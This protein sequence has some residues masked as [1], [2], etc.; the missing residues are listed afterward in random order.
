MTSSNA[1]I[2]VPRSVRLNIINWWHVALIYVPYVAGLAVAA[3]SARLGMLIYAGDLQWSGVVAVY[4]AVMAHLA[5]FAFMYVAAG[6]AAVALLWRR[7]PIYL[8]DF[9]TFKPPAS[10]RVTHEDIVDIHRSVERF[11]EE[12]INFIERILKRSE[13]GQAT[14]WPPNITRHIRDPDFRGDYQ[15][16]MQAAREESE[17]VIFGCLQSLLDKT[18]LKPRQI[19]FLIINCSLF[20]PTPSLCAMVANKFSLRSDCRTYSLGGMGCS[21]GV[22]SVD[23]AKQ[24]LA[25]KANANAVVISTENL[26]QQLYM[27]QQKSFVLQNTLFRVGGAAVLLSSKMSDG[28]RAKYKLLHSVRYQDA[29]PE[30]YE[31]VFETQDEEGHR[32]IRLS[33]EIT[34][35][36]GKALTKNLTLLGPR[37]LTVREQVKVVASLAARYAVKFLRRTFDTHSFAKQLPDIKP[38]VPNFKTAIQHF[39][40]HAGGRAVIDGIEKNLAL[41]PHHVEASKATLRN[42]G[43]T[44]SSSIWYELE[45]IEDHQS[46]KRGDRVLQIA[47][48]SGFKCNSAVWL[49]MKN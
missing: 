3:A 27:G 36:A 40:I 19:D 44:S 25:G 11:P 39:C 48:G 23:L 16:T 9:A 31:C 29:S 42:Y 5:T 30:A 34:K 13:T 1:N 38:Y 49:R 12:T 22:I 17:T 43:N 28:F 6:I 18:G 4:H 2:F 7:R 21:A 41:A 10:W 37:I 26:T 24:L 20:S 33:K 14:H 47:F 8:V 35:I 32:G 15:P 45:H 46:M